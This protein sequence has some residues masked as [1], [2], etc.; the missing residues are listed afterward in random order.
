MSIVNLLVLYNKTNIKIKDYNC[1]WGSL[2][3]VK[4]NKKDFTKWH[5]K[6]IKI[7]VL[8]T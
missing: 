4:D 7:N 6:W 8:H 2:G 3:I 1:G 5:G